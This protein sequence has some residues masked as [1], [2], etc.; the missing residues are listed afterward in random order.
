[1]LTPKRGVLTPFI[2]IGNLGF[3]MELQ[4]LQKHIDSEYI[5]HYTKQRAQYKEVSEN[6]E[7]L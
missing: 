5:N 3:Q 1:M 4:N 7:D 2:N 6:N